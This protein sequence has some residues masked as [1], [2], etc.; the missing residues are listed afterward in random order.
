M[1]YISALLSRAHISHTS[2]TSSVVCGQAPTSVVNTPGS[3]WPACHVTLYQPENWERMDSETTDEDLEGLA[4]E[5]AKENIITF[6]LITSQSLD[7]CRLIS[8]MLLKPH[9]KGSS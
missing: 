5:E 3:V 8:V 6:K 1:T 2:G 4:R 7:Y 9:S